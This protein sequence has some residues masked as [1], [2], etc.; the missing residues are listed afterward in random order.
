VLISLPAIELRQLRVVAAL[1]SPM[2][3]GRPCTTPPLP[4]RWPGYM[5]SLALKLRQIMKAF[6]AAPS[7]ARAA[8]LYGTSVLYSRLLTRTLQKWPSR[9]W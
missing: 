3:T 2:A 5:P 8:D 7:R 1:P 9:V 6:V 4:G